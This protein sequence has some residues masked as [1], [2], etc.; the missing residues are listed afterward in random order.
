MQ[1]GAHPTEPGAAAAPP[2]DSAPTAGPAAAA[3]AAAPADPATPADPTA[4]GRHTAASGPLDDFATVLAAASGIEPEAP[5]PL[6]A[7]RLLAGLRAELDAA[8]RRLIE[9]ARDRGASWARIATSLG[10]SSRQAAEQR[11]LRLS[12]GPTRDPGPVRHRRQRQR[13]IDRRFGAEI[14]RLRATAQAVHR[15]LSADPTWDGHD[16]RAAL[17][18]ATLGLAVDAAPGPLFALL[19]KAVADL[20]EVPAARRTSRLAAVR[21]RLARAVRAATPPATGDPAA[22]S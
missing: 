5:E 19:M 21:D 10:L 9:A 6:D 2:D 20:D 1:S 11:W 15:E 13:D 18:R 7:L 8:E 3:D 4:R 16:P 14:G 17:A 12:A 22:R